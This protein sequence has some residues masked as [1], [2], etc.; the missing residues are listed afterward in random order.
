[1]EALAEVELALPA[2]LTRIISEAPR[3]ARQQWVHHDSLADLEILY[4][5]AQLAD[6]RHVL[7]AKREGK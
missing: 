2:H 1:M 3:G 6:V 4:R 7:V 5:S